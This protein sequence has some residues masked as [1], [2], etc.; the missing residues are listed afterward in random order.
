VGLDSPL[1]FFL[2][3]FFLSLLCSGF[4]LVVLVDLGHLSERESRGG[5]VEEKSLYTAVF[6]SSH[7]LSQA[8]GT[9]HR[10]PAALGMRYDSIPTPRQP[11]QTQHP[12]PAD[13]T[14]VHYPRNTTCHPLLNTQKEAE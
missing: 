3:F 11:S 1:G 14:P 4:S 6:L 9:H 7:K 8:T 12:P 2:V 13:G 10:R 5:P